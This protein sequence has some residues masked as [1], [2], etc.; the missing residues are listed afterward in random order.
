MAVISR[1]RENQF[2]E[3]WL[4]DYFGKRLEDIR[5]FVIHLYQVLEKF[6]QLKWFTPHGKEHC[7]AV[8]NIL[9]QLIPEDCEENLTEDEKFFLLASA[10][11]HDIGMLRGIFGEEENIS[12]NE[13]RENHH[14]RSEKY[15][16][17]KYDE[18]GVKE[19]EKEVFGLMARFHRRREPL[20]ECPELIAI[21]EHNTIRLRLLAAYL[22]LADALH[23]DQTRTPA[24]QYAISLAYDIPNKSKLHWLRSK[25]VLG[26]N[27]DIRKK[28]IEVHLKYPRNI[29]LTTLHKPLT[30][31]RTLD[32]IHNLIVNDLSAEL[33]TVKDV[34]FDANISY[35]LRITKKIHHVDF[36][37]RLLK[38][39]SSVYN[40]YFLL[41]NPSSSSLYTL[42]MQSISDIIESYNI[43][44]DRSASGHDNKVLDT[45]KSFLNEIDEQVLGSRECHTGLR[46][47]VEEMRIRLDESDI[48]KIKHFVDDNIRNLEIKRSGVRFSAF[49]Y[50][51]HLLKKSNFENEILLDTFRPD[52]GTSKQTNPA[53]PSCPFYINILLYGYSELVIKTLC[54]FRD[55]ILR[56][57][58]KAYCE[59]L[60]KVESDKNKEN[61]ILPYHKLKLERKASSYFRIFI[62]EGQPK[63]RTSWGGHTIY[64]DGT[65]FAITLSE[66]GFTNL[67]I[68]PDA[69][70]APLINPHYQDNKF[71]KIDFVMVGA[72]GYDNEK[73]RHSAGHALVASITRYARIEESKEG[74]N[75][76]KFKNTPAF[77]LAII[78]DK[79]KNNSPKNVKTNKEQK[80]EHNNTPIITD[81]WKFQGSF[82][83]EPVRT[84]VFVSQDQELRNTLQVEGN[85]IRFYN[86]REDRIP[87]KLV[88][89]VITEKAW[90]DRDIE[91]QMDTNCWDGKY[92]T[93]KNSDSVSNEGEKASK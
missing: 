68:V 51:D 55:A 64:H 49:R 79:F 25:F 11:L 20:S 34:L 23:I 4:A 42:M 12:D 62:G 24:S 35:F 80:N 84:H 52:E 41:D 76:K 44:E 39:I 72:N 77:I 87:I 75:S 86:P 18:V 37:W 83:S 67:Y 29:E 82:G 88:D 15:I 33:D 13:I 92:I 89:I 10:W 2:K 1:E 3:K 5:K 53:E 17:R 31:K 71:P 61:K 30:M 70:A 93:D 69:I 63:N 47:I 7:E 19:S 81:G 27:I 57:L 85:D 45:I 16:T 9:H 26:I 74:A 38:D 91:E 48:K 90:L 46:N 40:Y 65:R 28:E 60:S 22:R 59:E 54:G 14:S 73:F 6:P 78:T 50:F 36:D 21:P 32:S 66:H 58:I 43:T 8:E 56:R